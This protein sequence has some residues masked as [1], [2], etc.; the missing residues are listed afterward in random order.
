MS[1]KMKKKLYIFG[2]NGFVG[3]NIVRTYA[4]E[5]DLVV[6]SRS[7]DEVFFKQYPQVECVQI[8]LE[9][10]LIPRIYDAPDFIINLVSIVTAERSLSLFDSLVSS[11][12]KVLV[13]LYQRFSGS[14]LKL[15]IQFGSVEEYGNIC[16]PYQEDFRESPDSPYGLVKQLTTNMALMLY[17]NYGFPVVVVRPSN[18]Y[19]PFQAKNKFIPYVVESLKR[20]DSIDVTFCEQK[21]DFIYVTDFVDILMSLFD[22]C[23]LIKGEI[24]NI[25]SGRSIEL[26]AIIEM[27]RSQIE[28]C[29]SVNYGAIPYRENEAMD[30]CCSIGKLERLLGCRLDLNN[31]KRIS[32]YLT[33]FDL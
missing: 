28:T 19:G 12:V 31:T 7:F 29:S 17:R 15:F 22:K 1:E 16:P 32:E 18:L 10:D 2:G 9:K 33:C 27:I 5:Y 11:N 24:I 8:D 13:N 4:K 26:R 3:K 6:F 14:D 21:R 20:G 23:D 30:L 25:G